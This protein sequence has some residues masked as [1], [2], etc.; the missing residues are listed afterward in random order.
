MQYKTNLKTL[1]KV[2]N[3][4][5]KLGF[6][7]ILTGNKEKKETEIDLAKVVQLILESDIIN[8]FCQTV[9]GDSKTDFEEKELSEIEEVMFGFFSA[10]AQSF[11]GSKF[12][13]SQIESSEKPKER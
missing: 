12:F 8:E 13:K 4:L 10:T 5:Q 1:K 2:Y 7:N 3:I 11:Q 9:T 6:E